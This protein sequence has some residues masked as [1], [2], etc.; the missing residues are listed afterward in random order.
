MY[1]MIRKFE[2]LLMDKWYVLF[3]VG[4][5]VYSSPVDVVKVNDFLKFN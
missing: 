2:S 3:Y 4:I 1:F 5:L